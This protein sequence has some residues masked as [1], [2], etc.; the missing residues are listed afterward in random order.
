VSLL[1]G[2]FAYYV[3]LRGTIS[4]ARFAHVVVVCLAVGSAAALALGSTGWLTWVV[5]PVAALGASIAPSPVRT[6]R[7][8]G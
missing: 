1:V 8:R 6:P 3:L 5:T 2:P 4:F 7:E